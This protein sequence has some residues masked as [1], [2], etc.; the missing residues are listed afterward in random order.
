M[1]PS[2]VSLRT[3]YPPLVDTMGKSELE[4]AAAMLLRA[5]Q[6]DGDVFGPKTPREIGE[7]IKHDSEADPP[8]E[9]LASLGRTPI[10]FCFPDFRGL[11]A[12]G[13]A[14]WTTEDEH[15]PVEFT[16]AGIDAM[17]KH[18]IPREPA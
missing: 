11:V 1:K 15:A 9:P 8:I 2:D 5:C 10:A 3:S 7:A 6:L 18:C 14:R 13:F 12:A 17:S 4:I 16:Q